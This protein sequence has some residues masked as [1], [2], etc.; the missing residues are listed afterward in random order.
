MLRTRIRE[1]ARSLPL[2]RAVLFGSWATGRATARSDV[3]LLVVYAGPAREDAY[4]IVR[5][6]VA[7]RGLEP[8]VYSEAEAEVLRPLLERMTRGGVELL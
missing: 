7:L 1:L 5:T 3:D 6:V 2:R 8:H 4:R